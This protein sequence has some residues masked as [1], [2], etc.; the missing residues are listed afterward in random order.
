MNLGGQFNSRDI[1]YMFCTVNFSSHI[2]VHH[3]S[4]SYDLWCHIHDNQVVLFLSKNAKMRKRRKIRNPKDFLTLFTRLYKLLLR[5][6]TDLLKWNTRLGL[7]AIWKFGLI[8]NLQGLQICYFNRWE[9]IM[10]SDC[11]FFWRSVPS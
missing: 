3:K 2:Q 10:L 1:Y 4:Y 8:E 9:L 6:S 7:L 11:R 5:F